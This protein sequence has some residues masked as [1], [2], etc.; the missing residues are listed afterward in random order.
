MQNENCSV[1]GKI[2]TFVAPTSLNIV[3]PYARLFKIF[4]QRQGVLAK[5]TGADVYQQLEALYS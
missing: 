1:N 5:L 2:C 4:C 3:V